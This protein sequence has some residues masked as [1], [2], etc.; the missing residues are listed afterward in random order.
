MFD[1]HYNLIKKEFDAKLLF[2]NT[3]FLTYEI[4]SEDVYEYFFKRKQ[5]FDFT[6][7]PKDSK[8]FDSTNKNVIAKMKDV[9]EGKIIDEFVGLKSKMQSIKNIDGEEFNTAKGV[10]TVTEFNE[11]NATLSNK[12]VLRHKMRKIQGKK[13]K[14]GICEINKIS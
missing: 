7:Y 14:I 11:F 9:S 12:K 3:D 4:K 10:I 8:F 13:H 1:F 2:T 6:N 5:L